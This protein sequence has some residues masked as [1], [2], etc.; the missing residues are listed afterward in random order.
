MLNAILISPLIHCLTLGGTSRT[1]SRIFQTAAS[2]T[3]FDP[4][5]PDVDDR[6]ELTAR[7]G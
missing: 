1:I 2:L 7:Y 3:A 4:S 5:S 6:R